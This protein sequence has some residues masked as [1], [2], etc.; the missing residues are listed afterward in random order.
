MRGRAALVRDVRHVDAGHALEQLARHVRRAAVAARSERELARV[1][2]AVR[3]ELLHAVHRQLGID[4]QHQRHDV[5]E[6]HGLEALHRVVR[7]LLE[8]ASG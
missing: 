8:H 4:H 6:D 5:R 2:L 3:D 7:Q 1:G